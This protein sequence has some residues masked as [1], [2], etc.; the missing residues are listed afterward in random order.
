MLKTSDL[1]TRDVINIVDGRRL[2][3]VG[4]V[5]IDLQTGRIQAIVVPGPVRWFGLLGRDR[6]YVIPWEQIVR[7]GQ[8]V[9]LVNVPGFVDM[10]GV[11]GLGREGVRAH[12]V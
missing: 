3:W 1:R 7:F 10:E 8:D 2:G 4:D 11:A 9:I 5:E 12:A 6:D